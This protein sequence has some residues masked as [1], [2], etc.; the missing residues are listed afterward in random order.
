MD[1]RLKPVGKTCASTGDELVPGGAC[2]SALVEQQGELVRLDFSE[3]GWTGPPEGTVGYWRTVV[4]NA[5]SRR[6]KP[7][8]TEAL[9]R[10]FEQL[11][12]DTNPAQA[13]LAWVLSLLLLQKRRLHID[14]ARIDG[15]IEYVQLSGSRGEGPFEVR[16]QNLSEEE[17]EQLQ[18]SLT[19]QLVAEW[20]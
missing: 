16:D 13:K 10:Y 20:S 5:D 15:E 12:E 6:D 11:C 9:L 8:D 7:L 1:Y 2:Y 3:V 17:I 4:P 18:Q 19:A 14:G